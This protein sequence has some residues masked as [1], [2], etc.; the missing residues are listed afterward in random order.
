MR[1][2]LEA[3]QPGERDW[4]LA[5][6]IDPA[7]LPEHIAIIMDGNGRWAAHRRLPR[8]AGHRAG[9][10]PVRSTVETCAQL[11]VKVLT[12]YAFS[13]E[14]WKR[15][16]AEVE[17][18][19]R[20]LRYYL[21]QELPNL[22]RNDVRMQAI[23]R[24]DALPPQVRSELDAV[25]EATSANRGL[26]LNLAINYGGRAEIVDAMNA[27]LDMA[28][29]DGRLETLKFDEDLIATN[30]Y[31]ASCPDP[32]LLIRT[33]GEMRIS[34]F[35]LWQ[36]AYAELYVTDTLW[37]DFSRTDLLRAV[38][39]Y[40]KRDRRYG[41]L[42]GGRVADPVNGAADPGEPNLIEALRPS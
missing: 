36:I 3:L 42:S 33:S 16:R 11:G 9:V 31:T 4:G 25:L 28:R 34:N 27:I 38:L 2:L 14:N 8:V 6:A 10:G 29:M 30:L 15:P 13:I 37:P 23:G 41:G 35:L 22:Q 20:L 32:D 5:Q 12:L 21:K 39:E 7:R 19:W 17:M 1:A 18:L 40:Q 24:L 26:L